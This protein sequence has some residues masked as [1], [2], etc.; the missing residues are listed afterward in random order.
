MIRARN[1]TNA[2]ARISYRMTLLLPI[3]KAFGQRTPSQ[4]ATR[5]VSCFQ[6]VCN[7]LIVCHSYQWQSSSPTAVNN[8]PHRAR[9]PPSHRP[10]AGPPT[11]K[12][13]IIIIHKPWIRIFTVLVKIKILEGKRPCWLIVVWYILLVPCRLQYEIWNFHNVV[14]KY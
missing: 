12:S 2:H 11:V 1:V 3:L 8:H 5:N 14:F 4:H 7:S 13:S 9:H 6:Y 10:Q